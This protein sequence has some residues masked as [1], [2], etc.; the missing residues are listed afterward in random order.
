VSTTYQPLK[1]PVPC[2]PHLLLFLFP[3][4]IKMFMTSHRALSRRPVD[5]LHLFMPRYSSQKKKIARMLQKLCTCERERGE[6]MS[7]K[8]MY[9][10]VC[11]FI[12]YPRNVCMYLSECMYL[13]LCLHKHVFMLH[14]QKC[15]CVFYVGGKKNFMT[16]NTL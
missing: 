8:S 5:P 12:C 2:P 15:V 14:R 10:S 6:L 9:V 4:E 1:T 7:D 16:R 11:L 3:P 13:S